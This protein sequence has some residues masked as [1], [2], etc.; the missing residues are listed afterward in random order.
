M[1]IVADTHV[2][3][4]PG[5]DLNR[6]FNAAFSNLSRLLKRNRKLFGN[7]EEPV[8]FVICLTERFDCH[9]FQSLRA[10]GTL[11]PEGDWSISRTQGES[12][13]VLK[14]K[15]GA[16]LY[17]VAGRQIISAERIEILCLTLDLNIP[18]GKPAQEIIDIILLAG[19]VPVINWAPGKWFFKRGKIVS[20]LLSQNPPNKLLLCD[21]TLRPTV[22]GIPKIMASAMERGFNV[23]A[24]SDPL[25]RA[26]EERLIGT[27]GMIAQAELNADT[28]ARSLRSILLNPANSFLLVGERGSLVRV[29]WR[30][31]RHM[32]KL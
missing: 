6:A 4:Y 8:A 19:G 27:Y 1:L 16:E 20:E 25:P 5:Y 29:F 2:H 18:D 13:L 24:G 30:I 17:L 9:F 7:R 22:W 3:L 28:P 31:A 12:S 26:R 32:L 10:E 11:D 14:N 15:Q 21:T 23:I